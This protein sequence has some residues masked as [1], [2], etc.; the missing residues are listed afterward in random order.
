MFII[1]TASP[2]KDGLTA[3]YGEAATAGINGSGGQVEVFDLI[4]PYRR[5]ASGLHVLIAAIC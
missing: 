2:N 5:N 4:A 3:A 1:I